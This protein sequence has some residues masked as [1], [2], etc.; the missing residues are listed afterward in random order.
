[1]ERELKYWLSGPPSWATASTN[2]SWSS[3]VHRSRGFGSVVNTKHG[4]PVKFDPFS[5]PGKSPWPSSGSEWIAE[6]ILFSRKKTI[7]REE[8]K[9]ILVFFLIW[10]FWLERREETGK[11]K[12]VKMWFVFFV[13]CEDE[14]NMYPSYW[15]GRRESEGKTRQR[16]R[17]LVVYCPHCP[18][19]LYFSY[20]TFSFSL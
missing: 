10:I 6:Y 3:A 15:R 14:N 8:K 13:S 9:E 2:L 16:E 19:S 4:S 11:R 18:F 20:S 5:D 7:I 17:C 12:R 1:M